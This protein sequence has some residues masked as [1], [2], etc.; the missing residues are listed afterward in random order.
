MITHYFEFDAQLDLLAHQVLAMCLAFEWRHTEIL[1][2]NDFNYLE[3]KA[4][5]QKVDVHFTSETEP[6]PF[7]LYIDG[8]KFHINNA[9]TFKKV[10]QAY[11]DRGI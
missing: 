2:F 6:L 1:C 7:K 5:G 11:I 10:M 8:V 4:E 3:L 9:L